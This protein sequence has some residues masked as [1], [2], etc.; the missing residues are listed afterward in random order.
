MAVTV[1]TL[2]VVA[3]FFFP[4]VERGGLVRLIIGVTLVFGIVRGVVGGTCIGTVCVVTEINVT[5]QCTQVVYD[6]VDAEVVTMVCAA[7]RLLVQR[8]LAYTVDGI[9][10]IVSLFGHAVLG[11]LHYHTA[12]EDTAEVGTLDT[13]HQTTSING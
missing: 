12:A 4:I 8:N 1:V 10:G 11:T 9:V 3:E 7:L 13:V 5:G 2:A 6:I